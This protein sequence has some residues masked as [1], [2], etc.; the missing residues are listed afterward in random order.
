[1][2]EGK[3]TTEIF[4]SM[5]GKYDTP[6]RIKIAEVIANEIRSRIVG[7]KGKTA[8]DYGCGTGLVGIA[9]AELFSPITFVDTSEKMIEQVRRKIKD[10]PNADA[11]C[12][13]FTASVPPMLRADTIIMS[14]TLLHIRDTRLILSRLYEIL[15]KGGCLFVVDYN[16]NERVVSDKIHNGFK[17]PKLFEEVYGVGF[18]KVETKTF[19]HGSNIFMGQDASLFILEAQK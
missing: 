19:Y 3:S 2:L 8:I 7:G 12:A 16:K 13:D 18:C 6:E 14:Q 11:L 5:A 9:L 17:Q 10:I 15:N 1:M 4:D